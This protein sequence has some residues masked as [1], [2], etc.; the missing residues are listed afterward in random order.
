MIQHKARKEE[1]TCFNVLFQ[2]SQSKI[3]GP[4]NI[5]SLKSLALLKFDSRTTIMVIIFQDFLIFCQIFLS[6][7]EKR[8]AIIINKHGT[9][10]LLQEL[11]KNLRLRIFKN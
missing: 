2:I 6:A 3:T 7:Q 11:P 1:K 9:Y 8:N 5:W 4:N 10:K